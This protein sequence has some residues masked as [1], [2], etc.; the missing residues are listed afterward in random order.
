MRYICLSSKAS[1][2][3]I[4]DYYVVQRLCFTREGAHPLPAPSPLPWHSAMQ[5]SIFF[6]DITMVL[7]C[8]CCLAQEQHSWW[9][10]KILGGG[11]IAAYLTHALANLEGVH[12]MHVHPPGFHTGFFE[13][14]PP[15][16]QEA[17]PITNVLT[18]RIHHWRNL[19]LHRCIPFCC[20]S[21]SAAVYVSKPPFY[22]TCAD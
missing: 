4:V 5:V 6:L 15:T 11:E 3:G 13:K 21:H 7:R 2:L 16:Y 12:L 1:Y 8:F 9:Q 20:N 19:F 14:G 17:V 22:N 18:A 10:Q